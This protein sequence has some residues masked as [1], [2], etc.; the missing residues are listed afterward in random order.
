[1]GFRS[2]LSNLCKPYIKHCQ[3]WS[4]RYFI[5]VLAFA[6]H[7]TAI[8]DG[9]FNL[10]KGVGIMVFSKKKNILIPNVG[11]KNIL[12]L[13]EEKIL[14]LVLS[15]NNFLNEKKTITPPAS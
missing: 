1:M 5:Y 9:P 14:T 3:I 13:V 12:I 4:M 11:E 15:E 10:Q 6:T 8:R 2:K 7:T